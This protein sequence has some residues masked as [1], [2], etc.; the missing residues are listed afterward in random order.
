MRFVPQDPAH[1]TTVG[2]ALKKHKPLASEVSIFA[3]ALILLQ[4]QLD[5]KESEEHNKNHV[6]DFLKS[7]FPEAYTTVNTAGRTDLAILEDKRTLVLIEAK[8]PSAKSEFPSNKGNA[9]DLNVKALHE[10]VSYYLKELAQGNHAVRHLVITDGYEWFQIDAKAFEQAFARDNDL[11]RQHEE[12][13]SK[14][15]AGLTSDFYAIVKK[16]I[17]DSETELP[18]IHLDLRALA[19]RAREEPNARLLVD[20]FKLLGPHRLLKKPLPNFGNTLNK[21]FY[22]EL[23]HLLGLRQVTVEGRIL[24]QRFEESK[25]EPG[26]LIENTLRCIEENQDRFDLLPDLAKYGATSDEQRFG[27]AFELVVTWLNRLLFLKL[28]EGQVVAYNIK[29]KVSSRYLDL[30]HVDSL[31]NLK[32]LF[33]EVL[34]KPRSARSPNYAGLAHVP[35]LN[36]SLFEPTDKENGL[37]SIDRL[38]SAVE[39][40]YYKNTIL[41]DP[42]GHPRTGNTLFLPYLFKFLEAFDFGAFEEEGD[43][44][45]H[46]RTVIDAR[47]L[48]LVFEKLNGF[49]DGSFYTP[50]FVTMFMAREGVRRAVVT[51][52]NEAFGWNCTDF[53]ELKA[54][55][56]DTQADVR[57]KANEVIAQLRIV[58]PAVGSGHFLVSVL[59]E[60]IVVKHELGILFDRKGTRFKPRDYTFAVEAD[61]LIVLDEDGEPFA[62]GLGALGKPNAEVQRLQE[63]IFHEKETLIENCLFGVD[64]NP[65]SVAICR[66]RLWIELLKNAYY[67]EDSEFQ[68]METLPN[69]DINIKAGNSLV[70][71]F[72]TKATELLPK[73][74]TSLA[75]LTKQLK[76]EVKMYKTVKDRGIKNRV[77]LKAA[78]IE[79]E[80][81]SIIPTNDPEY[82]KLKESE[83]KLYEHSN[84]NPQL[85]S[86][87]DRD[88]W[89][90]RLTIFQRNVAAIRASINTRN[91]AIYRDRFEWRLK[92]P[93]VLDDKGNFTGFDLVI[94]NPPYIRIQGLQESN[95]ELVT[96][97]KKN[98]SSATGS[99]D[100]YVLF[101]E[102]TFSLMRPGGSMGYI[103]PH[104]FFNA[105]FGKGARRLLADRKAM[106]RVVHFRENQVF[107]DA[108]TYTCLLFCT[109]QPNDT[110]QFSSVLSLDAPQEVMESIENGDENDKIDR[111]V[112]RTPASD[113]P[114]AFNSIQINS[115]LEKIRLQSHCLEDVTDKIFVGLQTSADSIYVL[116]VLEQLNDTLRCY[117]S[118]LD[119]EV[120]IE[121]GLVKPFLKGDEVHRYAPLSPEHV[122]IFPYTFYEDEEGRLRAELMKQSYIKKSF[123]TGWKYLKQNQ[124]ALEDREGGKMAHDQFYAYIYPKNLVEFERKKIVS[125][126]IASN[127]MMS[128]DGE[129]TM[130]HT[131]KVYGYSFN[132]SDDLRY[133]L[134]VLNSSVM[135]FFISSTGYV[136]RGGYF[137]FKSDYL[138]PF[139]IPCSVSNTPPSKAQVKAIVSRVDRV[140][141]DKVAG[142]D[143]ST[144]EHEINQLVY[145]LYDLTEAEIAVVEASL[146]RPAS[147]ISAD[148][149]D[150]VEVSAEAV[151]APKRG[152]KAKA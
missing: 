75:R 33:F 50:G 81:E 71:Q 60:L 110:F 76:E 136:L 106:S 150:G 112:I 24:I 128:L 121:Q 13:R 5:P 37:I 89:L 16:F 79:R 122:V 74:R 146:N 27:V 82:K 44:R 64:I 109:E 57:A 30:D 90:G 31:L 46:A 127:C 47:V 137:T 116:K 86:Q 102:L 124:K 65:T 34:A 51:R 68:D 36:S 7:A 55:L 123:P 104:K 99:F 91:E 120:I 140:L 149:G 114:W 28:L 77:L 88:H 135:W 48:G 78:E 23:L 92:F 41:K 59:N 21:P 145:E 52:M 113:T 10:L 19:D 58:D 43:T 3:N 138:K 132:V 119:Q 101:L 93:E 29:R 61:E 117:S 103:L 144:I 147:D 38:D 70:S 107:G 108:T 125:A 12:F 22:D 42:N 97:Y 83:K 131:T 32:R 130:Y 56:N 94:G 6:R 11:R 152:R 1:P 18:Y 148:D 142:R 151:P 96:L 14:Q 95:P 73:D 35:Y 105:A 134:G 9:H 62:Y 53:A 45:E 8:R 25:R 85:L 4:S 26:S 67:T 17:T 15:S 126:E 39:L 98:Y 20:S 40:S 69:L 139:P 84:Q 141:A 100:I 129:G 72:D 66:L 87:A 63:A 118:E 54:R 143:T 2:I 80:L 111:A 49:K 133:L 115:V